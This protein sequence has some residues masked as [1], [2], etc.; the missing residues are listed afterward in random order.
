MSSLFY[1]SVRLFLGNIAQYSGE[2]ERLMTKGYWI[3][4]YR[5]VADAAALA[6]YAAIAGPVIEAGGGRFLSRGVAIKAFEGGLQ[7]RCVVI[8]FPSVEQAVRTY[9]SPAYQQALK[10]LKGV[11]ERDVRIVEGLS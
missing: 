7:E 6:Q 4:C 5:S 8:E 3:T 11:V 1:R 9:E 10:W 2:L